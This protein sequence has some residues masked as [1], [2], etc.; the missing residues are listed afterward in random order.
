MEIVENLLLNEVIGQ[1]A[2]DT[3]NL[4]RRVASLG[5]AHGIET[6]TEIEHDL[7]IL[8]SAISRVHSGLHRELF[9]KME[10]PF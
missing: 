1:W 9:R 5:E 2:I 3:D 10:V 4:R 8:T 7:Q 6:L